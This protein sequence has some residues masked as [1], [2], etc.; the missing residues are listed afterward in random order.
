M[1]E[2]LFTTWFTEYFKDTLET[3]HSENKILFKIL[4]LLD[5]APGQSRAPIEMYMRLMFSGL[6]TTSNF[7][8]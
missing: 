8:P 3:Y 1:A 5:N 6:L 4:L 2:N 7:T